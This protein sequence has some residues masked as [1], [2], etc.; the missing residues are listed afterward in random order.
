[1]CVQVS[2]L[3]V[4]HYCIIWGICGRFSDSFIWSVEK[5]R[6]QKCFDSIFNYCLQDKE[7]RAIF[8][9]L[10]AQLFQGYRSCLQ[11]IRIHAEPVIHFHKVKE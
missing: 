9:R 5:S 10:F 6:T 3:R 11:L 7:V 2:P 4:L 8:L 1:M